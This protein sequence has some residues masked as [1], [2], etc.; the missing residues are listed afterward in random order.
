MSVA[1]ESFFS[2]NLAIRHLVC[3]PHTDNGEIPNVNFPPDCLPHLTSLHAGDRMVKAILSCPCSPPRPLERLQGLALDKA[4]REQSDSIFQGIN[5]NV[6]LAVKINSFQTI[7]D[8]QLLGM[9]FPCIEYLD[10]KET[11]LRSTIWDDDTG[12]TRC[13]FMVKSL[14]PRHTNV[15]QISTQTEWAQKLHLAFQNLRGL[16][17]IPISESSN[18]RKEEN[19]ARFALLAELFPEIIMLAEPAW[20]LPRKHP[21]EIISVEDVGLVGLGIT[22]NHLLAFGDTNLE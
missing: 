19:E 18:A 20:P 7:D 13:L 11:D 8:L 14:F 17:G 2:I 21:V 3:V 10:L 1:L 9:L 22:G 15:T 4:F 12:P 5:K 16:Y 6:L